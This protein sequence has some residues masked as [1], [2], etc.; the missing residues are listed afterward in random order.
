MEK[1]VDVKKIL[2]IGLLCLFFAFFIFI[3]FSWFDQHFTHYDDIKVEQ[4]TNYKF[5]IFEY[6][7]GKLKHEDGIAEELYNLCYL[8][9]G[10]LYNWIYNAVNFSKYWTYAPGQF[11]FTFALLPLAKDYTGVKFFGRF[12]SL[13]FGIVSLFLCWKI[14]KKFTLDEKIAM[15]GTTILGCSW[16]AILYCMHMSNYESIILCGFITLLLVYKCIQVDEVKWWLISA[17]II[18]VLTWF[19]YQNLCFFGGFA[20]VYLIHTYLRETD[21]LQQKNEDNK[22][23]EAVQKKTKSQKALYKH[24]IG[25]TLLLCICYA[26]VVLPLL[27]FANMNG[28]VTWNAGADGQF[29]FQFKADILYI[30]KFFVS[31]SYR[32]FKAMLSPVPLDTVWANVYAVALAVPFF[33]GIVK[34]V[35]EYKCRNLRFYGT[36]FCIGTILIEYFFVLLGKFTL[37]PTRHCNVLIPVF[38][39]EIG[40]GIYYFISQK[41]TQIYKYV[42]IVVSFSVIGLWSVYAEGIKTERLDLFTEEKV[43]EIVATCSPD[44]VID[45]SAPQVWYLL[46]QEFGRREIVDYQTDFYDKDYTPENNKRI[47]IVS[48]TEIIDEAV[49]TQLSSSLIEKGYLLQEDADELIKTE[50]YYKYEKWGSNDFDLYNVTSGAADNIFYYLYILE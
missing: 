7:F 31:N 46:S 32:V 14:L 39:F 6:N 1:S 34:G 40:M 4:L 37:S 24:V 5:D 26:I 11:A 38:V 28:V 17:T 29:L 22:L 2:K 13:I 16:Q 19:H 27:S 30:I 21:V 18:G 35:K 33:Y 12:P 3:R 8:L 44:M 42:P 25:G 9:F 41:K 15:V 10:N 23:Q 48:H 49:L 50:C 20:F 36:L 43:A 47:L 45:R